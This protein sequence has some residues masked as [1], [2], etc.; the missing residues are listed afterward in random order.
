[1]ADLTSPE[2]RDR[3]R[4]KQHYSANPISPGRGRARKDRAGLDWAWVVQLQIIRLIRTVRLTR[5]I[6]RIIVIIRNIVIIRIIV[7]I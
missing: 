5:T 6:I 4:E 1:M 7:I 3:E 2:I